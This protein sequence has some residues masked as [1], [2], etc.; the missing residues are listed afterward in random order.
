MIQY[1]TVY[2]VYYTVAMEQLKKWSGTGGSICVTT[3]VG[4]RSVHYIEEKDCTARF[5]TGGI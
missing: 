1:C 5:A 2:S 4:I 3:V